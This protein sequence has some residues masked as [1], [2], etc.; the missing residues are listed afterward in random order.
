MLDHVPLQHILVSV[1]MTQPFHRRLHELL[2]K[3]GPDATQAWLS[4]RSGVDRSLISRL[5]SGDRLPTT[6]TLTCIAPALEVTVEQLVGGTDAADRLEDASAVVRRSDYEGVIKKLIEYEASIGDLR[7]RLDS[8]EENVAR[9]DKARRGAEQQAT[10]AKADAERARSAHREL[11]Q[12]L[13]SK[14]AELERYQQALAKAVAE[15]GALR[16]QVASLEKEL[17]D[18]KSSSK[19]AAVLAGV[20]AVAGVATLAH[21]L[22]DAPPKSRPRGS[23]RRGE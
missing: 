5:M 21:F 15:F 1:S 16:V 20:S 13:V 8:A 3:R 18:A 10:Q 11:E 12:R 22:D 7:R 14:Q 9:S 23:K 6:E 17:G 4:E 19:A 2:G